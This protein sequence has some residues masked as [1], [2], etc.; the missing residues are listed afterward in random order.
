MARFKKI[1]LYFLLVV[2]VVFVTLTA[3]VFYYKDRIINE[4]IR[5]ANKSLNT[6]VKIGKTDVTWFADFPNLSIVFKDVYIEDSHPGIYPL[7]TANVI[8]FQLNVIDLW[9]G[10][11]NVKGLKISDSETNLKIN[12][13]GVNNYTIAKEN[14]DTKGGSINFELKN[15]ALIN[16]KVHYID[17]EA[18]QEYTFLSD[19]LSASIKTSKDIYDI[20]AEG[21]LTTEKIK[22]R[23][24]EL[25]A[26]KR[27]N[28]KADLIYDD[29]QRMLTI[30]PSVLSL[31]KSAF[32]IS[33]EYKWKG[34]TYVDLT[35]RA[36]DTD[37]QT[38]LSLLPE[39]T[40]KSF[41]KYQSK[42]DM[43]FNAKLKGD[44]TKNTSPS[45][46]VDFGFNDATLFHPDY[47][48]R[49]EHATMKGSFASSDVADPK[50]AVLVLKNIKGELNKKEFTADLVVQ[51]F[52]DSDVQLHF[53]GELD[54]ASV[55][56]FYPVETIKSVRG[57]L[58]ADLNFEGRLSWLKNRATATKTSTKGSVTL[59]NISLLYGQNN[60]LVK[61]VNGSL[62]FNNNDLALSDVTAQIGNS[63]F[64]LNG[65][66]KNVITFLLFEDQPIGIETD[67][68]SDFLD[69]DQLFALGFGKNEKGKTGEYEFSISRNINLNF[70]CDIKRLRYKRFK[71]QQ[72]KGDVLVKN[73]MAVSRNINLKSMGGDMNFSGIVDAKNPK[74]IDVV[75][76]FK[77]NGIYADSVFYVFENFRQTFIQ[78][79]HLKGQA[80]ADVNME[81]VLNQNL[82]LFSETL[83]ADIG[84]VI[85]NGELN[86]F[87]P[88]KKLGKYLDDE[89]LDK[90]RFSDLKNEV[91]I[92]KKTIYIPQMEVRTNVTNIRISGTHTLD[93]QID[94]RVV[95]PLRSYRKINLGEAGNA[96]EN[97]EGQSRLYLKVVGTTDNYRVVYDTESVKKKIAT[98]LKQEVKELKEAFQTKGKQKE[99]TLE[100]EED[101]YFDWE[102]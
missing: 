50:K 42:G 93:Q 40:S 37:I 31:K 84:V 22:V 60:I 76:T 17:I 12:A 34:K 52:K 95:A 30:N 8:S 77:L 10:A 82:K 92:E 32:N 28:V 7:L 4:F 91:H 1:L 48:S 79:K 39:S 18:N 9:N 44:A 102:N 11:Y 23:Q 85:K 94:Y 43:Y 86:N 74:A 96:V 57:D 33:G 66:F 25:F 2:G 98:D 51:N 65:F 64:K 61:D 59:D 35:A 46:S 62:Q 38:L 19:D 27:F 73:Q 36:E 89:G 16:T 41:E 78:D 72:L 67:L 15:V 53:S 58:A 13:D 68:R 90:V 97:E 55:F 6:P 21:D 3:S 69:L 29:L 75:S 5:Q 101:E 49:I 45:L 71:A 87:E 100:L 88:I 26:G 20:D 24:V 14:P 63:D 70:N 47:H 99:K 54:A 80:Y 83:I 56:D 81:M